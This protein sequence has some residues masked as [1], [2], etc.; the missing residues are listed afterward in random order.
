MNNLIKKWNK[1]NSEIP[2][3]KSTSVY[4]LKREKEFPRK[5][6]ICDLGGGTGA[7]AIYFLTQGHEVVLVDISD[8]ALAV[9]RDKAREEGFNL[10]I[11]RVTLGQ[12][13]IPIENK[14]V[15]VV[16]SRLA[17]HYFDRLVLTKIFKEVFRIM[18]KGGKA[19]ITVKSPEDAK[20]MDF[21][22]STAEEKEDGVYEDNGEIK[23]RFTIVQLEECL[24]SAGI[25]DFKVSIFA[26]DLGGR[27][28]K[29]KSGSKQ[30]LLNEIRFA[31]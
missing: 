23:S 19:F 20:E 25:A 7:D 10:E 27:V 6:I 11:H 30:L 15:N 2:S 18:K 17:L 8:Y 22:R 4:A 24:V 3:D 16:Y 14:S 29:V 1:S 28:D 9:A 26:E 5:S 21:L 12:E 31:K 13:S